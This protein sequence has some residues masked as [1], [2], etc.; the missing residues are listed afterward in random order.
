MPLSDKRTTTLTK[1]QGQR[2]HPWHTWLSGSAEDADPPCLPS[3]LQGR[4]TLHLLVTHLRGDYDNDHLIPEQGEYLLSP[5]RKGDGMSKS[6]GCDS[7]G[8]NETEG[9]GGQRG[10]GQARSKADRLKTKQNKN[11]HKWFVGVVFQNSLHFEFHLKM[12]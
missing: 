8:Q 3:A 10:R 2:L 5:P 7:N 1:E 9:T 12:Q 6:N 4:S 11:S